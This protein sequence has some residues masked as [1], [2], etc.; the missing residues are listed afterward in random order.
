M[1]NCVTYTAVL[2]FKASIAFTMIAVIFSFAAF[3][4]DLFG[5]NYQLFKMLRRNAILNILTG[6]FYYL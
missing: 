1:V 5:P 6:Q 3:L 4:L 2:F